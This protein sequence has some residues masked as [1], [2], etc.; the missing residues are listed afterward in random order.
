MEA[1]M[2]RWIPA[3][4]AAALFS[5]QAVGATLLPQDPPEPPPGRERR[6]GPQDLE[7]LLSLT[8]DQKAAL[9]QLHEERR[10]AERPLREQE[11]R[12]D[13]DVR[14]ALGADTPDPLVVGQ[15]AIALH[16]AR[17]RLRALQQEFHGRL[18][19]LLDEDQRRTLQ[20]A[21][22]SRRPPQPPAAPPRGA[23]S[24]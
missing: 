3:L 8:E 15:A 21:E 11:R 6:G 22:R 14:K 9:R 5:G 7:R 13:E 12:L 10:E 23:H 18:L 20:Q 1:N 19:E 16:G 4:L 2:K 17:E 24:R